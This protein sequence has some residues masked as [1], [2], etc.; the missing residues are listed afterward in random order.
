MIYLYF[1]LSTKTQ[2]EKT[3]LRKYKCLKAEQL[4]KKKNPENLIVGE[5]Y[6]DRRQR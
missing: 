2:E 1:W 4:R 5:Q 3:S 6:D